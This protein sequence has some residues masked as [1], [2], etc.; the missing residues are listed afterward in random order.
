L[1]LAATRM[2]AC[3]EVPQAVAQEAIDDTLTMPDRAATVA[4]T[5]TIQNVIGNTRVSQ[6]SGVEIR[7]VSLLICYM[8]STKALNEH[9][10]IQF[11]SG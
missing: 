3:L 10:I 8:D 11:L 4:V 1:I 7:S 9:S 5:G 6:P 2:V